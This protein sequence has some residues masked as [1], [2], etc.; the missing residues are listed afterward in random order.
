MEELSLDLVSDIQETS[1]DLLADLE[2]KAKSASDK[3]HHHISKVWKRNVSNRE[4]KEPV[5]NSELLS[6]LTSTVPPGWASS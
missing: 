5:K 3:A 2:P 1:P 6:W 4:I